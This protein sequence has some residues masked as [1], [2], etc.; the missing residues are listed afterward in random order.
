MALTKLGLFSDL[1][2]YELLDG[3]LVEK[4]P[5]SPDHASLA[6]IF[7][8]ALRTA[9]GDVFVRNHSPILCGE[10]DSPEPDVAVV[11]GSQRAFGLRHPQGKDCLIVLEVCI[12]SA[13]RDYD[14]K[15]EIYARGGVPEYWI[16]DPFKPTL[17]VSTGPNPDGGWTEVRTYRD[18]D[19][20]PRL[21]ETLSDWL[22]TS[23]PSDAPQTA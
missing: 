12:S 18:G 11:P 10:F 15:S 4:M 6:G 21:G 17:R 23:E 2:N 22:G 9:L 19:L 16:L 3:Q 20:L 8:D 1:D 7:S 5:Q 14:A 13:S